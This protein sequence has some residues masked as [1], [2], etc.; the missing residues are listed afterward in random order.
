MQMAVPLAFSLSGIKSAE[1]PEIWSQNLKSLEEFV[2]PM[3]FLETQDVV[4]I[5]ELLEIIVFELCVFVRGK[6]EPTSPF[7]FQGSTAQAADREATTCTT[8]CN[9]MLY[10]RWMKSIPPP[11]GV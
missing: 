5:Q 8:T 3:N 2:F 1:E 7:V 9:T 6:T 4:A 10:L 11:T